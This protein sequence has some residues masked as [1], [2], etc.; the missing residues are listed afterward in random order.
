MAMCCWWMVVGW[1]DEGSPTSGRKNIMVKLPLILFR[2]FS[3]EDLVAAKRRAYARGY[4]LAPAGAGSLNG[5]FKLTLLLLVLLSNSATNAQPALLSTSIVE[6]SS[7]D[8]Q[9]KDFLT[10]EMTAHLNEIKSYDPAPDKIFGAGT[11]GEY[12][13]GTFMNSVGAYAA[14]TGRSKLGDHDLAREVGQ[15]GLLEYRLKGT[16]FCQLL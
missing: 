14:L 1:G 5:A 16:R 9:V 13:W 10:Q 3:A 7:F 6:T 8:K 12:T 11:T 2:A 4:T 15:V